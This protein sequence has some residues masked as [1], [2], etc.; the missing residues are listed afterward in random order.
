VGT[1]RT[2]FAPRKRRIMVPGPVG[3]FA[4]PTYGRNV[5]DAADS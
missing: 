2:R 1:A 3:G 5:P 4:E